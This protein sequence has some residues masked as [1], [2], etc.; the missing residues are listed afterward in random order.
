[1]DE[2]NPSLP[3]E[4]FED[5]GE[6]MLLAD[7]E[8]AVRL[9]N[10]SAS[11]LLA[12]DRQDALGKPCW[13]VTRFRTPSGKSFCGPDCPIQRRARRVGRLSRYR[14]TYH[15]EKGSS[16]DIDLFSFVVPPR[17]NGRHAVLHLLDASRPRQEGSGRI[18][19]SRPGRQTGFGAL[20][21]RERQV[22]QILAAGRSTSAAAAELGISS[23]TVR[24]HINSVLR[25]LR[26]H[27]RLGAVLLWLRQQH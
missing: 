25:K 4:T 20:S 7:A 23:I 13:K 11:V 21:R 5:A 10:N 17:R 22:L 3:L 12:C 9:L 19:P 15:P 26:V 1:V 6:A 27:N 14:V 18:P 24:N 16:L 2:A 8:G